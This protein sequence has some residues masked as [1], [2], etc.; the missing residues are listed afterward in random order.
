MGPAIEIK[1]K[2]NPNFDSFSE[3]PHVSVS[4][5]INISCQ[6]HQQLYGIVCRPPHLEICCS[7]DLPQKQRFELKKC[8][9]CKNIDSS[10]EP[11]FHDFSK[12][13]DLQSSYRATR[14]RDMSL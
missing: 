2:K 7:R 5:V 12:I 11:H 8:S 4:V 13:A 9:L 14:W 1:K 10:F 6:G 3:K